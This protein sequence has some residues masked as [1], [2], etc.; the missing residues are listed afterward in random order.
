M[1]V[2][3]PTLIAFPEGV[4]VV[5]VC[6]S[7]AAVAPAAARREERQRGHEPG[8]DR[9]RGRSLCHRAALSVVFACES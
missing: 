1:S 2:M 5:D 7:V 8:Q 9:R 3:S 4:W 6:V